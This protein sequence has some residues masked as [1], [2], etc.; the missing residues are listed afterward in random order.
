MSAQG[1]LVGKAASLQHTDAWL[2]ERPHPGCHYRNIA[3]QKCVPQHRLV[4]FD[5]IPVSP[6]LRRNSVFQFPCIADSDSCPPAKSCRLAA[7]PPGARWPAPPGYLPNAAGLARFLLRSHTSEFP[8]ASVQDQGRA[9]TVPVHRSHSKFGAAD[10]WS[11]SYQTTFS[12]HQPTGVSSSLGQNRKQFSSADNTGR[13]V[14]T[15]IRPG[16]RIASRLS[17]GSLNGSSPVSGSSKKVRS[18]QGS[19]LFWCG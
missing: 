17:L 3:L 16:A 19:E 6:L 11:Q 1:S 13:K 9:D 5:R 18:P 7:G 10:V 8:T 12:P 4:R 15:T 2:I 14:K